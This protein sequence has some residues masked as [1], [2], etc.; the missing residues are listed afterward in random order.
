MIRL[1]PHVPIVSVTAPPSADEKVLMDALL[2]ALEAEGVRV[3]MLRGDRSMVALKLVSLVAGNDLVIDCGSVVDAAAFLSFGGN[4]PAGQQPDAESFSCMDS[5]AIPACTARIVSWLERCLRSTP[6]AG[7]ILIGGRSSRMGRPK[8]LIENGTGTS[9]VEVAV[10]ALSPFVTDLVISGQGRLPERLK[11]LRRIDDLPDIEGPLAGVGA[12]FRSRP[13]SSWLVAACDMP[14]LG[15]AAID[16]LLAQ[17]RPGCFG[18]T[19][20]NPRT[21]RNEPLLS[22][23]D[24]RCGPLIED[25]IA[26]GISRVSALSEHRRILQPPIPDQ[27]IDCWRNINNPEDI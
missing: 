25:M 2:V 21:G 3:A 10:N 15:E 17:R 16:W 4:R 14:H 12:L 24:Y 11:K 27:L 6:V 8:H 5:E 20:K 22:W 23:Y 9:W 19:P 18:V 7:A 13:F 26:S 1:P